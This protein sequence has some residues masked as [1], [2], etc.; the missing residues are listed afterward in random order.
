MQVAP[1]F[2]AARRQGSHLWGLL[3]RGLQQ[4]P[5]S[6]IRFVIFGRGRSGSTALVS[7]LNSL[8]QVRCEGEI[9]HHP[10][11]FPRAHVLARCANSGSAAYGCKILSYQVLRVQRIR[12]RDDFVRRLHRDGFSILYLKRENLIYHALSNIRA[13]AYGFHVRSGERP[14]GQKIRLD[15]GELLHWIDGSE[16]LDR[17]EAQALRDVPHLALTYERDLADE[18]RQQAAVR[19]ICAHTGIAY[20][21]ARCEWRKVSPR[22]LR[23]SIENY[24]EL[25]AALQGTPYVRFLE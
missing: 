14:H 13:R 20:E 12:Q 19:R 5:L 8:P 6:P 11:P 9:L 25:A 21:P 17:F 10:V 7:L 18:A 3:R 22:T 23:E 1:L 15:P 16:Q 2:Q 4:P 24:D